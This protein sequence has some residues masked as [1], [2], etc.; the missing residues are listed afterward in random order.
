MTPLSALPRGSPGMHAWVGSNRLYSVLLCW[1]GVY[2]HL[3]FRLGI[4]RTRAWAPA[5][6]LTSCMIWTLCNDV[7]G[8]SDASVCLTV[9]QSYSFPIISEAQ[10][11][12]PKAEVNTFFLEWSG[13]TYFRLCWSWCLVA[14][15][16]FGLCRA[17]ASTDNKHM[18][19]HGSLWGGMSRIGSNCAGTSVS[20]VTLWLL[21]YTDLSLPRQNFLSD[22]L[23]CPAIGLGWSPWRYPNELSY[24]CIWSIRGW[25]LGCFLPRM[26][27]SYLN[28]VFRIQLCK[29]SKV[30]AFAKLLKI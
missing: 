19:G 4:T 13:S 10:P 8:S 30:A 16:Q 7:L 1:K 2:I 17:K 12:F 18:N 24:L 29:P 15:I 3:V 25:G 26:P 23:T 22:L 11:P 28:L 21:C 27:Q 6:P 5:L 9:P 20:P 14:T